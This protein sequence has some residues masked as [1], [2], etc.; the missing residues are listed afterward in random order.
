[1]IKKVL[2]VCSEYWI[3]QIYLDCIIKNKLRNIILISNKKNEFI[4]K[5]IANDKLNTDFKVTKNLSFM[6]LKNQINLSNSI[7][8][9]FGSPWIISNDIIKRYKNKIFNIHQSALPQMR[10]AVNSYIALYNIRAI[11]SNIHMITNK[12]D[13]GDV[14]YKRDI[15]IDRKLKLPEEINNYIQQENRL[16]LSDFIKDHVFK[17]KKIK[18][19]KQNEF[20]STYNPRLK[21]EINGWIN[22]NNDVYELERFLNAFDEPYPGAHTMLHGKKVVL[23]DADYSCSDA[24]KHNFENGMVLRKFMNKI[25]ISANKGSIYV[26]KILIGKKNII[27]KIKP[28]D[29]FYTPDKK[30]EFSKRKNIFIHKKR[31]YTKKRKIKKNL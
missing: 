2:I 11:Q 15:Y 12:I 22:W 18:I 26:G 20:F 19:Y 28:G 21:A 13:E 30:L 5:S 17:K 4:K 25:V 31:I 23:K 6:W 9:S 24:S 1:M 29:I 7:I 8:I 3:K 10:G 16:M 14:V 27:N